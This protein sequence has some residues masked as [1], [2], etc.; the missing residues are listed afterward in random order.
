MFQ[1]TVTTQTDF[2]VTVCILMDALSLS[3]EGLNLYAFPPV[4]LLNTVVNKIMSHN[5][6]VILIVPSWPKMP[7]FCNLLM[8]SSQIRLCLPPSENLITQ[9]LKRSL[10][11]DLKPKDIRLATSTATIKKA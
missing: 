9:L 5:C 3:L 7:L 8:F 6:K 4:S 11:K 10:H 2:S 1:P